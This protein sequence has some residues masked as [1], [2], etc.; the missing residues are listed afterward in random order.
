MILITIF[1]WGFKPTYNSGGQSCMWVEASWRRFTNNFVAGVYQPKCWYKCKRKYE[2]SPISVSN[3]WTVC[4]FQLCWGVFA[5]LVQN[6]WLSVFFCVCE[7]SQLRDSYVCYSE[8]LPKH[9]MLVSYKTYV[10]I[11]MYIYIYHIYYMCVMNLCVYIHTYVMNLCI[12]IYVYVWYIIYI[13]IFIYVGIC[14]WC[15]YKCNMYI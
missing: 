6:L 7:A 12:N 5:F 4:P 13:Y 10:Y 11:Y 8:L 15:I 2:Q 14:I 3:C 9:V 1:R